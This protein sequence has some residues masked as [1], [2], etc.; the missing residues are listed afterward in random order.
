LFVYLSH[1][2]FLIFIVF[3][4]LPQSLHDVTNRPIAAA[5]AAAAAESKKQKAQDARAI[6]NSSVYQ[7]RQSMPMKNSKGGISGPSV[8]G[9]KQVFNAQDHSDP[10]LEDLQ[11]LRN[12]PL[13]LPP[14][15][16]GSSGQAYGG[17]DGR[18]RDY[19]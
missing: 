4:I 6:I 11:R 8:S 10:F 5:A 19:R 12:M 7:P 18:T 13:K 15:P 1:P 17:S 14:P 2:S 9:A 3:S 16:P